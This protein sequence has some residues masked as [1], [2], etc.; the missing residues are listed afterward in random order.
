MATQTRLTGKTVAIV[1][2]S[3]QVGP[4]GRSL[5]KLLQKAGARVVEDA[6]TGRSIPHL[7]KDGLREMDE[8]AGLCLKGTAVL[9]RLAQEKPDVFIIR[10]GGNDAAMWGTNEAKY[11]ETFGK[12]RQSAFDMG[13]KE[14]WLIAGIAAAKAERQENQDALVRAVAPIFGSYFINLYDDTKNI[15]TVE[16]GRA[17]DL[18]HFSK[19]GTD[20][21]VGKTA[22]RI[23][24]G[25]E[26]GRGP[27]VTLGPELD[28]QQLVLV[29]VGLA[30]AFYFWKRRR[31]ARRALVAA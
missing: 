10:L 4:F 18:V 7:Y 14:V 3:I 23:I 6:R 16:A 31:R 13:A 8:C 28:T 1:G 17:K 12:L 11:V 9:K 30:A 21:F 19:K 2:D 27:Q 29:A 5:V 24:D 20:K 15:L 22:Q 25:A 26:G